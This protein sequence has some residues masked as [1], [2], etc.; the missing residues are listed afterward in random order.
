MECATVLVSEGHIIEG[1]YEICD[2]DP[3]DTREPWKVLSQSDHS[4]T[5]GRETREERAAMARAGAEAN[6]GRSPDTALTQLQSRA[7]AQGHRGSACPSYSYTEVVSYFSPTPNSFYI[8]Y[9][10]YEQNSKEVDTA[11]IFVLRQTKKLKQDSDHP[12][13]P[14][15]PQ[16]Y[17]PRD[18]PHT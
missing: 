2:L 1:P 5:R 10:S 14:H 18:C 13:T 4:Y 8:C 11:G 7:R 15:P 16:A 12:L 6:V 9:C 17:S 3:E